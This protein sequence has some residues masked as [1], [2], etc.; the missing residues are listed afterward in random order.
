MASTAGAQGELWGR[1]PQVWATLMEPQQR[2]LYEATL[3]ALEPLAG[4]RLLDAGCGAGLALQMAAERGATVSGL[5][6]S[7]ALLDVAHARVPE[8][9]LRVG[10]IQDLP[11]TRAP[12]TSCTRSTPCSTPRPLPTRSPSWPGCAGPAAESPWVSGATPSAARPRHCSLGC[13]PWRHRH[14]MLPHPWRSAPQAW[15]KAYWKPP[16]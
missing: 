15:S 7:R 3:D 13:A 10:D 2:P 1:H 12:S 9:E 4:V 11:A 14:P 6:A 5:D 16:A 8:A